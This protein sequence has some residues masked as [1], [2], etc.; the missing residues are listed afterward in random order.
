MQQWNFDVQRELPAGVFVDI[1]YA[2]AKGTHL[3]FSQFANQLP[4]QYLAMGNALLQQVAN[5]F[6]GLIQSG[7]LSASTVARG[8]LLRP[9]PQYNNFNYISSGFG[10]SSYNSLQ[11]KVRKRFKAGGTALLA[12]TKAK[13][14]SNVDDLTG[15]LEAPTGG[16]AGIQ[17]WNDLRSART[18]SSDDIPQRL[19]LSYAVELPFG[20][21][22]K[23]LSRIHGVAG[24]LAS[25]WG[26]DGITTLQSGFPLKLKTTTNQ[27]GS[28][29]G[30][31]LPNVSCA[32][33]SLAGSAE[34][35][36]GKWFNTSCFSLPPPFTFGNEPRVDP[37]LRQQ[38]IK[39][40]DFT[41][42]K[43]TN[44]GPENKIGLQFRAEFF[45]IFNRPQFGPPNTTVGVAQFGIISSQV[46]NPRL[47]QL[48]LRCLF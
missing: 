45:N 6:F 22:Q 27:T 40:F 25:G 33:Q 1:A 43:T 30:G 4:D 21:G 3:P 47:I 31:S 44:F 28:F 23:F 7:P 34:E 32:S 29:G 35:R 42:R 11:L 5:P 26:V 38:G 12:Y 14:I 20:N 36:L 18:L 24:K 15:W 10:S 19:V 2:G 16:V 41:L 9:Y 17:N 8:Q 13:L 37:H 46:N 48:A 39:N